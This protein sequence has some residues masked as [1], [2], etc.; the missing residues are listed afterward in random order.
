MHIT[1]F[2]IWAVLLS[3]AVGFA[4]ERPNILW[5]TAEDMSPTL[6]CYGD[7]YA[8]TPNIDK[9][10]AQ[11]VKYTLAFAT[12]PVCSPSRS[13][14]ITG[15]YATSLG[16]QN[17][18]S[19]FPIPDF[20]KG[21]P[22][23]L[24]AAGYYTT[25]NV[26]TDYNT[27][28]ADKIIK[29][30]WDESSAKAH[31]RNRPKKDQPFFSIFNLMTSHQSRTMV[32]PY[33]R[34]QKEV[35]SR[36]DKSE[37]HDPAKAPLPPYYP[38]TP[39]IHKTVA[40]YYD[41]VTAMDKE[42]GAIL[43]QLDDDGLAD[44]TIVFF[45]S[46]HGSGMP[47]HKR[48]LYDSGMRV[49]MLIR[50]PEKW[51]HLAPKQDHKQLGAGDETDRLVSFVDFGPTVLSLAEVKIP[52][53]MQ[54]EPFLG[55]AE[56]KPREYV[57]GHRDRVDEVIDMSRSVRS[58]RYLYIRNYMPQYGWN[59]PSAW[60]DQGEIRHEFYRL[61]DR[62]KMTDAQW[63]FAGPTRPVE[64]LYDC[65]KD[66]LNVHN[67]ISDLDSRVILMRL[68]TEHYA[69]ERRLRDAGFVP[70]I[71][72]WSLTRGNTT[73]ERIKDIRGNGRVAH[74][75]R[76]AAV[77]SYAEEFLQ[78][79]GGGESDA[80]VRY[81]GANG[82]A[83]QPELRRE[84][85]Q[86][87]TDA[88]DDESDAVRIAAAD[89]LARHGEV[90]KALPTL[91]ELVGDEDL[92]TVLYAARAIELLGDDAKAA[93]P[94][95]EKALARAEKIRPPDTPATV[96]ISGEADMAMFIS[97]ATK[98]FLNKVK[99]EE[100]QEGAKGTEGEQGEQ[101][102][103]AADWISLFDGKT[104]N[105]WTARAKGD[106]QVKDGEIQ[107]LSQGA[108]L[109]LVQEDT[110]D[111]FELTVEAKMPQDDAYNSGIGFRCSNGKGEKGKP[112]GY[113]CEIDRA[114]SGMIYAIGS[115]WVWPKGSDESAKFKQMAGD[116]FQDG[117][118]NKFRI[119]CEGDHLQIWINGTQTADVHDGRFASG[120]IALQHH[121]KGGL[122]RFRNVKIRRL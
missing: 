49:P 44:D 74:A 20:I 3:P 120:S 47:R 80:L 71:E 17:M 34:F 40:R 14:L 12:A 85:V 18:R 41:C 8:T 109:W 67:L 32:W 58:K 113:Q 81:W 54:G 48:C 9:L 83:R 94:A 23:Y 60:P 115:G 21:F 97:F 28:N 107:I 118:W 66:P 19:A 65:E 104:L 96:V 72:Q 2:A 10:A 70:E 59:Q 1:R 117:Q 24:R 39:I 25:N 99:R 31:W 11:S 119:R 64:E 91:I 57:F 26:K 102:E 37:I 121:G 22:S 92:T 27:A 122:H 95:M 42:V 69:N 101:G 5:I 108:N 61:A 30:S 7:Q 105:G 86:Q 16:T 77:S 75:A 62:N 93:V 33:E 52:D 6:G 82:L 88:L 90:D 111:N 43:K 84:P 106:V 50:F 13:T 53:Y 46:D 98:A 79:S 51:K 38:D 68:A 112:K 36:L 73:W 103:S 45:Y 55:K 110:F 35:Q 87:L 116:C 114:K 29:A 63:Q 56:T 100:E 15:C 78:A 89:A 4:G 76:S